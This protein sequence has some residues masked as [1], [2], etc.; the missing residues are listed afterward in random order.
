M[1]EDAAGVTVAGVIVDLLGAVATL[2]EVVALCMVAGA[3]VD[4]PLESELWIVEVAGV[5][6]FGVAVTARPASM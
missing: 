1:I 6:A 5:V 2:L 3:E 4:R